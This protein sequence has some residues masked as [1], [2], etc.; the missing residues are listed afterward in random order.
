[1]TLQKRRKRA[2][3]MVHGLFLVIAVATVVA[4]VMAVR[5]ASFCKIPADVLMTIMDKEH[6]E[7]IGNYVT[8]VRK[9]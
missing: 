8:A 3:A 1:M 9:S 5:V 6:M 4:G 7:R 2:A